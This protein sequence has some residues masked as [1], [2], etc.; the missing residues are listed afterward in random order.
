MTDAAIEV[1][2][3]RK[4][5]GDREAVR[6]IAFRVERGEV[7]SLLGPNGAGK[8]TTVEILEGYRTADA[9]GARVLGFDP[10]T[11]GSPYRERIGI[12]LQS[13]G[14]YPFMSVREAVSL[15]AGYYARPRPADD[16]IAAVG[17]TEQ[18]DQRVRKLSGGQRRRLDVALSL[19]GSPELIFLDEPT[20][21]FDPGA[22]RDAWEM[23]ERLAAEGTTILLTTHYMDE[24]HVLSDRVAVMR[25]G[26]IIAAGSPASLIGDRGVEIRFGQPAAVSLAHL[27]EVAGASA[28][29][30]AERVV[31]EVPEPTGPLARLTAWA[32]GRGLELDGLEVVRPSLEDVYL[33]LVGEPHPPASLEAVG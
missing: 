28:R 21:G 15:F 26:E 25:R 2:G 9:G 24:A 11:G 30:V 12:V 6:G 18:A 3:L 16:V 13:S 8:T 31:I 7:F 10:A 17:L 19:V 27:G 22:R 4:S 1:D 33:E 32:V 5:Y 14:V 23:I 20:T 29:I